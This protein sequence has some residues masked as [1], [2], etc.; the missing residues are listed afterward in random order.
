MILDD[1]FHPNEENDYDDYDSMDVIEEDDSTLDT[2]SKTK[3]R[4]YIDQMK[5]YDKGFHQIE[6]MNPVTLKKIKISLYETSSTPGF[7]IRNA[8]SG[9][10]YDYKVGSNDE[11]LLFKVAFA[12]GEISQD[13]SILFYSTPEQFEKHMITTVSDDLKKNWREKQENRIRFLLETMKTKKK[14]I[15]TVIR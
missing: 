8:I 7:F 10:R 15:S 11:D 6:K 3:K 2:L 4:V 1:S 9:N 5:I 14:D 12:T 13:S